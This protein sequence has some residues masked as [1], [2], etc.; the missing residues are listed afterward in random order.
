[1]I[2]QMFSFLQKQKMKMSCYKNSTGTVI[3]IIF[4]V[5]EKLNKE[6]NILYK[7]SN[8]SSNP[9]YLIASRFKSSHKYV[10]DVI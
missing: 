4:N 6:I 9:A 2:V 3:G 7:R 5:I 8:T 10:T 1:M